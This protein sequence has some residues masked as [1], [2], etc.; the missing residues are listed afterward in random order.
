MSGIERHKIPKR[1]ASN[2]QISISKTTKFGAGN[3]KFMEAMYPEEAAK[4]FDHTPHPIFVEMD[5]LHDNVWVETS[6][7]IKYEEAREEGSERWGKPHVSSLS[8]HSLL[9]LR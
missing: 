9:N 1:K 8:F 7:W 6:R 2:H 4:E 3:E 5:E